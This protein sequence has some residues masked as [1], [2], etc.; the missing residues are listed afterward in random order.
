[1]LKRQ[2]DALS[3]IITLQNKQFE[4]FKTLNKQIVAIIMILKDKEIINDAEIKTKLKALLDASPGG[5]AT[6][7]VQPT[8][9]ES[10]AGN[11]RNDGSQL[12]EIEGNRD[13][14][15]PEA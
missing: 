14:E 5:A 13:S 8:G 11:S 1:M 9:P 4:Q 3:Q 12:P 15:S 6:G 7:A 2:V 10:S